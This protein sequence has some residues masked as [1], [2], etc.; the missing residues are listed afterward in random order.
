MGRP[1][2]A[3]MRINDRTMSAIRGAKE[4]VDEAPRLTAQLILLLRAVSP[5]GQA[6]TKHHKK[7][8]PSRGKRDGS[9]LVN[10]TAVQL[11]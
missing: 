1:A 6:A 8:N 7:S 11:P 4:A 2:L 9:R 10:R 5:L 3:L